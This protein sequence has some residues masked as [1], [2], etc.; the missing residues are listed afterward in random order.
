MSTNLKSAV[1]AVI[2]DKI[3]QRILLLQ[4]SPH[5]LHG[6]EFC[7]PGGMVD[8]NI[9]KNE[10]DTVIREVLEETGIDL[11]MHDIAKDGVYIGEFFTS[12][13]LKVS[14]YYFIIDFYPKI[15]ICNE[16]TG[17]ILCDADIILNKNNYEYNPI[18][19]KHFLSLQYNKHKIWGITATILFALASTFINFEK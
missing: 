12:Y 3:N 15:K 6:E 16:S 10:K 8:L 5:L 9:D 1:V 14:A 4:R 18:A 7:L 17:Y 13:N 19:T 11:D 2:L